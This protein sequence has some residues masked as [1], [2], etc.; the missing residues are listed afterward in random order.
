MT[1]SVVLDALQVQAV[2]AGGMLLTLSSAQA[3]SIIAQS[4]PLPPDPPQPPVVLIP[5][6]TVKVIEGIV[7][8]PGP[9]TNYFTDPRGGPGV[10]A[11]LRNG[12][13]VD[14]CLV[15]KFRAP[16]SPVP[17]FHIG[18][19][20]TGAGAAGGNYMRTMTLSTTPADFGKGLW[21]RVDTGASLDLSVGPGQRI[22]L[23]AGS[24]YYLNICNRDKDG[25]PS[26]GPPGRG[27][28]F[29]EVVNPR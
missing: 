19:S 4:D 15:F 2:R 8:A 12:F 14:D 28:V 26:I 13:M 10:P 22:R 24:A 16:A 23:V 29:I 9:N 18:V 25:Q 20:E 6:L 11:S 5:G 1:V 17:Y 7:P 21:H 27:D 3:Q